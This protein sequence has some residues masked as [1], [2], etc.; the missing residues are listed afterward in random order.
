VGRAIEIWDRQTF[1]QAPEDLE[2]SMS[3]EVQ[4]KYQSMMI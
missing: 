4:E 3:R 1:D 2:E